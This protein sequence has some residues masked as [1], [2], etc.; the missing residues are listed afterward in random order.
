MAIEKVP[1][2]G[3]ERRQRPNLIK[4]TYD[5]IMKKQDL[6][7]II[8]FV[9][10]IIGGVLQQGRIQD[11]LSRMQAGLLPVK[12]EFEE[13]VSELET[14]DLGDITLLEEE[15]PGET[16]PDIPVSGSSTSEVFGDSAS[17]VFPPETSST[18]SAEE[19]KMFLSEIQERVNE[20]EVETT[21]IAIKV[22]KLRL[23]AASEKLRQEQAE[24]ARIANIKEQIKQISEQIQL[25]SEQIS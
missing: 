25:L 10:L 6:L 18:L 12:T 13:I 21:E 4:K 24:Q 7:W 19:K 20:I 1:T 5:K 8:I 11:F 17:E 14:I 22:T 23:A 3:F 9:A 15:V 16:M 2:L